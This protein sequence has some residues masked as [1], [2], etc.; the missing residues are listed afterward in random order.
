[1]DTSMVTIESMTGTGN[2][3]QLEKK[4]K[5]LTGHPY[6][7][8]VCNA[9]QALFAVFLALDL[10][11]VEFITTPYTWPGS[12]AGALVLGNVPVFGDIDPLTLTLDPASVEKCL[13]ANTKA[14]LAVDIYGNP[15]RA[16]ALKDIA[17]KAAAWLILDCA[18]SFG[19]IYN[20]KQ[21]GAFADV[22]V[23]S[24]S[25]G[26]PLCAGEGAVIT[27]PHQDLYEKLIFWTQHP[28]RQKRDLPSIELNEFFLNMRIHP[29]AAQIAN[30]EFHAV[31]KNIRTF[32]KNWFDFERHIFEKL[33]IQCLF[34]SETSP[35]GIKYVNGSILKTKI[36]QLKRVLSNFDIKIK[37]SPVPIQKLIID[38]EFFAKRFQYQT[39]CVHRSKAVRNLINNLICFSFLSD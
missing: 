4:F 20:G 9:T 12:L 3:Y 21:S 31:L 26:K 39:Y 36:D 27:T 8:A 24:F 25:Y 6:A 16:D 13:S 32:Q 18:Q 11:N 29:L 30:S 38:Y 15:C 37:I 33:N 22:A 35:A 7:V 28:Y 5:R 14:I 17:N 23:F 34:S 10:R 19:A 1:M 2:I